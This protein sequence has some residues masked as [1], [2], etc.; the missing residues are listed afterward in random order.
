M[1][2]GASADTVIRTA[3]NNPVPKDN[4][5][6]LRND[7]WFGPTPGKHYTPS[8]K[9]DATPAGNAG[10]AVESSPFDMLADETVEFI[11]AL[12][13]PSAFV[14][15]GDLLRV[16]KRWYIC[17]KSRHFHLQGRLW[18]NRWALYERSMLVDPD[19][20]VSARMMDNVLTRASVWNV[21][22][23][24][25]YEVP[26]HTDG[27]GGITVFATRW[28]DR[29]TNTLDRDISSKRYMIGV[30]DFCTVRV[31]SIA[32]TVGADGDV[33][34]YCVVQSSVLILTNG[35]VTRYVLT[36]EDNMSARLCRF[37]YNHIHLTKFPFTRLVVLLTGAVY[38]DGV[39]CYV[40]HTDGTISVFKGTER[41]SVIAGLHTELM[42]R[43]SI[44]HTAASI[45][46]N[47]HV[48]DELL[49]LVGR[50][51]LVYAVHKK[52]EAVRIY[53]L[54]TPTLGRRI[55]VE[56]ICAH[57]GTDGIIV[58]FDGE[59][60]GRSVY[61]WTSEFHGTIPCPNSMR[62]IG[63]YDGFQVVVNVL[64]ATFDLV[65]HH[66]YGGIGNTMVIR[67]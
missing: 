21:Y 1:G 27:G 43:V 41:V 18:A 33:I 46:N 13:A 4:K 52:T 39:V 35:T 2:Q 37:A 60:C 47:P 23:G 12:V 49:V 28:N 3:T 53:K 22:D 20:V 7:I 48:K 58:G 15:E 31:S 50:R 25:I 34:H 38:C 5:R 61:V 36:T 56:S 14:F 19:R 24:V 11:L 59:R 40:L 30:D 62:S 42:D 55:R 63:T 26:S 45:C 29:A 8:V 66:V 57:Y 54:N 67:W 44:E 65:G 9:D 17:L 32:T 64:R 16:C 51:G 6:C 10:A